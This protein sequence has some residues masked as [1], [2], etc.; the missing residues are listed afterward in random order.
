[1]TTNTNDT[2]DLESVASSLSFTTDGFIERAAE[3]AEQRAEREKKLSDAVRTLLECIGEDVTRPDLIKTPERYARAMLYF[4]RGYEMSMDEVLNGAIFA[5]S[6]HSSDMVIVRDIEIFS[7]CE[8]HLVPFFGRVHV[9]YIPN[10]HVLG[11]SKLARIAELCAR[12]LQVQERLTGQIAEVVQNALS[13]L[14]VGVV[15]EASHMCM[16][17]RGVQKPRSSTITSC[18]LGTMR[19]PQL[20]NEF[21]AMVR[22]SGGRD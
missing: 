4:T 5:A 18:M 14:G 7:L 8:H 22:G 11:L 9:G 16:V 19:E 2:P 10:G 15:I 21:M 1:M 20:R 3:N 13:P 17:M 6:G 12:R